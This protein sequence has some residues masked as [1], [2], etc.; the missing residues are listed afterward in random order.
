LHSALC[1]CVCVCV[2]VYVLTDGCWVKHFHI[3]AVTSS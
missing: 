3:W 2:Y 1:L